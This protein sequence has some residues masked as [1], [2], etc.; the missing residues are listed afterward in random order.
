MTSLA[1][2]IIMLLAALTVLTACLALLRSWL[3]EKKRKA[4]D[5]D[6]LLI[7]IPKFSISTNT[8]QQEVNVKERLA[9]IENLFSALSSLH[10][11]RGI[12]AFLYG[13]NDH[14]SLEMTAQHGIIS[15]YAAIPRGI[16]D[17]FIQQ[18]QTVYP[19]VQFQRVSD[20]NIFQ[21]RAAILGGYL[22]FR[23][24]FIFPIKTYRNFDGDPL[25][26]LATALS[27]IP[28]AS[29]AAIQYIVRSSTPSWHKAGLKVVGEAYKA[30]SLKVGLKSEYGRGSGAG[31]IVMAI[32]KAFSSVLGAS[33]SAPKKIEPPSNQQQHILSAKDQEAL[34]G[35]EEKNSKGGFDVN[36]RIIVSAPNQQQAEQL[37]R[38]LMNSF[39]PYNVYEF[40]NAFKP[41]FL[42]NHNKIIQDFIY[43][44]FEPRAGL[45]LNA[46]EMVSLY[47][48]PEQLQ[49]PNVRWLKARSAAP[50]TELPTEGIIL[51]R[52]TYRDQTVEVRIKDADRRRHVYIIGQT[53]TGKSVLMENMAIQDIERGS[54]ICVIDPHGDLVEKMLSHVPTERS[55]DVILF[56]PADVER[57]LALNMLEFTTPEQKT[58][59]VNEM[60][61]I[62]DK[63][64]DLR[65]TGGPMFE[66][67][68]RNTMLLMMEDPDSGS[69][70]LEVSRVLADE[71]FRKYKLS[72]TRN[73]VVRDFWE[74]EAQKAGGDAALANMVPYITSK[75]NQFVA[76]DIMRPIISQQTSS[77]NFRTV[78]DEKKILL[79]NLSKGKIGDM[80]STLLGMV[81]V[82]KLLMAALSRVDT[83]E[84]ERTDFYLYIDEFQNYVSESISIILSEARKYKLNLTMAHQY[85]NQLTKNNNTSVRDAVFGNV[86]TMVAFR[87]GVE[88]AEL[89]TQ[90]FAPVVDQY[91]VMNIEKYHAYIRLLIDN[92]N[93]PAF[94]LAPT[95]PQATNP[96][97]V[98]TLKELSRL[99]YGRPREIVE[100]GIFERTRITPIA[101]TPLPPIQ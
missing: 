4:Y 38:N 96:A 35:I 41:L 42:H 44:Y 68:M 77:F 39:G 13:R 32:V 26:S 6:V 91:D 55:D 25:E 53:G 12:R 70:L 93:P 82:G 58:F 23:K 2:T 64:Y 86:G 37:L 18:V 95:S 63:L 21:P 72:K 60:I 66:Q 56:D 49:A 61:N 69:T 65:T 48:L 10:A 29:G 24:S 73:P 92:Q 11:D 101:D 89:I 71:K 97:R 45:L 85:I 54:G 50:P 7:T 14:F 76:N 79:I 67:Y 84:S 22:I 27:K 57:P 47:H 5:H 8:K 30:G 17:F 59:V 99:K 40:G 43:R 94:S 87:V 20:Y 78:M 16:T 98:K 90:Q 46:E 36:I 62:F 52:S 19:H 34:K 31:H 83:D 80:N 51:G 81:C 33:F 74:K 88:D 75:L 3:H 15:F 28:S 9:Q 1:F 100:K